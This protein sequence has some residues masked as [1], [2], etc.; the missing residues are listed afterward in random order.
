MRVLLKKVRT[1][2]ARPR[3]TI[4]TVG[5]YQTA[6]QVRE[7][8]L[9]DMGQELGSVYNVLANDVTWLHLK[10]DQY[11][12]L[13]A[14]SQQRIDVLNQTAGH[15]F[16]LLQG[17]LFEGMVLHLARLTDPAQ[18]GSGR[19]AQQNLSLQRLPS[20]VPDLLRPE[21]AILVQGALDACS[22]ARVWRNKR[23]AHHDLTVALAT[24]DDPLP[25]IG[26]ADVEAALSGFRSLL[27]RL[28]LYY[29][30]VEVGYQLVPLTNIGG[31]VDQLVYYLNKGLKAE[32]AR[33]ERMMG[34]KILPEDI[35]PDEA[36]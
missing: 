30:K 9:N 27:N 1:R 14:K 31:D 11:R 22:A 26:Q 2:T 15:F 24:A 19:K 25:D 7:K 5:S 32:H 35:A 4:S 10:W 8:H 34:G 28:E 13:F 23:L 6:E 3:D 12:Q 21:V 16:R 18:T 33:Q 17:A 36:I 20:V 29:W